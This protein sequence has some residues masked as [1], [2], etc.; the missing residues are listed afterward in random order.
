MDVTPVD[1]V[2][3]ANDDLGSALATAE[4]T[5]LTI[6]A[7][8]LLG[9]DQDADGD[10]LTIA[11]IGNAVGGKAVLNGSGSVTFTPAADF[12]GDARFSYRAKDGAGGV[13]SW[14]TAVVLVTPV[15]D[16]PSFGSRGIVPLAAPAVRENTTTVMTLSTVDVDSAAIGYGVAGR[17]AAAF[18]VDGNVL[19]FVAPVD[20]ETPT[21]WNGDNI[22]E[23]SVVASDGQLTD[24]RSLA[25]GVLDTAG[26]VVR[27][28]SGAERIDGRH[29][30]GG[31]TA[32]DEEDRLDGRKGGDDIRGGDGNDTISGG[33][34]DDGLRGNDGDDLLRGG[35]GEDKINGGAG[36][37]TA[38]YSDAT[39]TVSV[40]LAGSHNAWVRIDGVTEDKVKNV[41]NVI[42]GKGA[43]V[44][45]GDS[46]VNLLVGNRGKDVLAGRLGADTLSGG[47]GRDQFMFDVRPEAGNADLITDFQHND[48]LIVLEDRMFRMIGS[49]LNKRELYA[50]DG[51]DA[52]HD[53]NDRIIYDA[54][55][56][57]LYYDADGIR[58]GYDPVHFATLAGAPTIDVG[59]FLIA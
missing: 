30:P 24:A 13:S 56:G 39:D 28:T 20:Y 55:T 41:E 27:G 57:E 58:G 11:S 53:R 16:A 1:D 8:R 12:N 52:P 22:Y 59:D 48:D 26:N 37:D 36:Q 40:L 34:G 54:A 3:V 15:N 44:L 19:R 6:S 46:E 43:D 33:K 23:V 18:R 17:D 51:A 32:T 45:I 49:K 14:A 25:I 4:D 10:A 21:D 35:K 50:H 2:P 42:G 5:A 9:N 38:D 7:A 29:G 47:R 31:K